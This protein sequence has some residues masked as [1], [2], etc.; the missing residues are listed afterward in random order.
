MKHLLTRRGAASMPHSMLGATVLRGKVGVEER[1]AVA[2]P[3][4]S[5]AMG[6]GTVLRLERM[7]RDAGAV[8]R[9]SLPAA[10]QY[11]EHQHPAA[12]LAGRCA[13][14]RRRDATISS[15]AQM[16][17]T[18]RTAPC[19]SQGPFIVTATGQ[20]VSFRVKMYRQLSQFYLWN[21]YF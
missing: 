11:R 4:S 2:L 5:I 17:A 20:C 1:Q 15:T 18:R 19:A 10:W 7:R 12:S 6:S 13:T 21:F 3:R 16:A 14:Q 9:T 8:V